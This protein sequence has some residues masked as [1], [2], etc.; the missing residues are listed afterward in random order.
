[1]RRAMNNW[2]STDAHDLEPKKRIADIL[3][4]KYG[5]RC[6]FDRTIFI[7]KTTFQ[8][9]LEQPMECLTKQEVLSKYE[10]FIPDILIKTV[11]GFKIVELDGSFHFE[12]SKGVRRTN[13]RNEYYEYANIKLVWFYT[14]TLNKMSTDEIITTFDDACW[15]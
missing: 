8:V 2:D 12:N 9:H 5:Y 3:R 11:S 4:A 13:K 10:I 7:D 15:L 1:M 14:P 6:V